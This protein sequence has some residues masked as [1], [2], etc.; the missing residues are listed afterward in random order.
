MRTRR[1]EPDNSQAFLDVN[2]IIFALNTETESL[3]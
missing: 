1:S 2:K 3:I